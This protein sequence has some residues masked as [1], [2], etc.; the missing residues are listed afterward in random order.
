MSRNQVKNLAFWSAVLLM[1]LI[2]VFSGLRLLVSAVFFQQEEEQIRSKTIVRDDIAY[3]PKQDITVVMLLGI[4]EWGEAKPS[5]WNEACAVDMINLV[6]FDEKEETV[7][8]L[9]L[10]RDTMVWMPKY[11]TEGREQGQAYRQLTY[12]HKFCSGMEDSCE[13]VQRTVS[14]FL[15]GINI[16]Y[17][18]SMRLDAIPIMNDAVGGVTVTVTEDFQQ[19]DPSIPMGTFTL[20]GKQ[21]VTYVQTRREVGDGQNISR[22]DR[23]REY[24]DGF[25]SAMRESAWEKDTF[26]LEVYEQIAPYL[27][28]N[29]SANVLSSMMQ[30][31]A[32]YSISEYVTPEGENVLGELY[33]E[34]YADEEKL[35]DLILRLFY[36]PKR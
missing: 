10:N 34:F 13:N 28:T 35:D 7:T 11:T 4:G 14:E 24:L 1:L 21:A 30:R 31:Y 27:V 22:M 18:V 32:D 9:S 5:E 17:Y 16:D 26:A 33:Y 15:G 19:I 25:I 8:L 36:A 6:I 2:F 20:K 29:C 3:F 12:S 23:Q